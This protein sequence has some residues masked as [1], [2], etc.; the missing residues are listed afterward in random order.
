MEI[1]ADTVVEDSFVLYGPEGQVTEGD[2]V[3][4][5]LRME[6]ITHSF[7]GVQD[8]ILYRFDA[9]GMEAGEEVKGAFNIISNQGSI[10]FLFLC[11]LWR[12]R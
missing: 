9:R 12:R 6:C 3:S 11:Q 10:T 8:E 4:S 7:S 2:V 5:D 1:H